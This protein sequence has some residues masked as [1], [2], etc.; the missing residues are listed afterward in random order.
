MPSEPLASGDAG[1]GG[2]SPDGPAE[3]EGAAGLSGVTPSRNVND[4]AKKRLPVMARL[5]SSN[6]S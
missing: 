5:K 6:R 1:C 2:S 3:R 4:G